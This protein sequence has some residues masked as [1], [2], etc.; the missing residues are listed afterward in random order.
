MS[1]PASGQICYIL[2]RFPRLSETFIL[3]EVRALERLGTSLVIVSL[4]PREEGLSHST[5]KEVRATTYYV[6]DRW[7]RMLSVAIGSHLAVAT[8]SPARYLTVAR[9][10]LWLGIRY[11]HPIAA[12]KN[13]VRAVIVAERCRQHSVRHIHAHFA[14]TPASVAHFLSMLTCLPFSFTTHAKDLYLTPTAITRERVAA[15][16][17]VLTC[18]KYNL[19]F[20]KRF[21]QQEHWH[22]L[23]LVYHGADLSAFSGFLGQAPR[24][25]GA[26]TGPVPIILSVGRLVRKKGMETLIE[27]CAL[28]RDHGAEFECRIVGNGPLRSE[29]E[30]QIAR[31]RLAGR[32]TLMGAMTH[33]RL[34]EIYGQATVF[35]LVPQITA[36]GDRDGIPNVLVEAMAAGV[37]VV[38][39]SVS[40]IPELVEHGR[41]GLLVRPRDPAAAAVAV[42]SLLR[43]PK[44]RQEIVTAARRQLKQ[45]FECWE[46]TKAIHA[47]LLEGT[48]S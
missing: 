41:T 36:D 40:G 24:S 43:D 6:P 22:K 17:F 29:L 28:L 2:K 12:L 18:T 13:F 23:H 20:L 15:A 34:V 44:L 37:P 45:N 30:K 48:N 35:A 21:V 11:G 1:G 7:P 27:V 9:R 14:N 5:V 16:K 8:K 19:G 10:A 38:S 32:V 33:D 26:G 31:L 47:L 25:K 42:E 4:L 46:S 3:N 39:T